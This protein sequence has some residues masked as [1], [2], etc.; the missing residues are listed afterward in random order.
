MARKIEE[1]IMVELS[2]RSFLGGAISLFAVS[3][4]VPRVVGNLPTI[5]ADGLHDD[6]GGLSALFRKEPLIFVTDKVGVDGHEGIIFH[7]G[8]YKITNTITLPNDL[9]CKVESA[10]FDLLDLDPELFA[11]RGP[12]ASIR[13]FTGLFTKFTSYRPRWGEHPARGVLD[14]RRFLETTETYDFERD[15]LGVVA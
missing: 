10:T 3:T 6:T 5:Y 1:R 9:F 11:L 4:F 12:V 2:R 15:E 13:P 7:S 8:R 14:R